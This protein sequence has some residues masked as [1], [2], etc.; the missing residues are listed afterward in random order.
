[1]P[2]SAPVSNHSTVRIII[3]II[4]NNDGYNIME[5]LYSAYATVLGDF[6]MTNFIHI[7]TYH[8]KHSHPSSHERTRTHTHTHTHTHSVTRRGW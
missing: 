8:P 1:M 4:N 2:Q 3:V 5:H 7:H 6:T